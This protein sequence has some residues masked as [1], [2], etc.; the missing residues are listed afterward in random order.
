MSKWVVVKGAK[1]AIIGLNSLRRCD[2][3]TKKTYKWHSNKWLTFL[4]AAPEVEAKAEAEAKE[5]IKVR[6]PDARHADV[7]LVIS[8]ILVG[9]RGT[10]GI[11]VWRLER[12]ILFSTFV[13]LKK[14]KC[15]S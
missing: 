11:Q 12:T 3:T 14:N 7:R 1:I 5:G 6:T 13:F 4:P 8:S 2:F 15:C 10:Y 9:R